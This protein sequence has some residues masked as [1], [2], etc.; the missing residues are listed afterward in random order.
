MLAILA[1]LD[2]TLVA[3]PWLTGTPTRSSWSGPPR[4]AI[5]YAIVGVLLV[6]LLWYGFGVLAAAQGAVTR[7]LLDWPAD[8]A[9]LREVTRSRARLVN[10]YEA[11]R[12]RIERDVH[13]GAQPRLTSLTLQLGL[14]RLDVPEGSP[15]ARRLAVAHDQAKDLMIML[16]QIVPNPGTGLT[17]TRPVSWNRTSS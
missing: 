6:P 17:C 14:A 4:Q 7:W 1:L 16:R 9:A 11:E 15:A 12:R 10:A 8:G 2:L 5:P 3:S 13:D